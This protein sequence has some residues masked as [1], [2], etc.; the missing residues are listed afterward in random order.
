MKGDI[1][2]RNRNLAI[3]CTAIVIGMLLLAYASVPLYRIFCRVT[4]FAG[5][6]QFATKIPSTIVKDRKIT[7]QFNSDVAPGLPWHFKPEKREVEVMIGENRLVFFDVENKSDHMTYGVA[8]YNVTPVKVG[9]YF[10]KIKCFCYNKQP[11]QPHQKATMPV[12]FF[13]DPDFMKDPDMKDVDTVTLSYTFF[14]STD[15]NP[16]N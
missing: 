7:V 13:I 12:S 16:A 5:T 3:N 11:L 15:K 10:N 1:G 8:S 6:T 2:R 14:S 9:A 4:G